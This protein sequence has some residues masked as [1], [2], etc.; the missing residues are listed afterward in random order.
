MSAYTTIRIRRSK[1]RRLAVEA[2]MN[3]SDETLEKVVDDLLRER[4][5]NCRVV[6]EYEQHDEAE[7]GL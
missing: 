5:Y 4:L 7:A 6:G 2:L 1:A 3:A